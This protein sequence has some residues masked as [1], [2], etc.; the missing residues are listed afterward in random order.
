MPIKV[1]NVTKANKTHFEI[2]MI[3]QTTASNHHLSRPQRPNYT[4]T[5][6]HPVYFRPVRN[7][8]ILSSKNKNSPSHRKSFPLVF[9]T[10]SGQCPLF[11]EQN[12]E[13]FNKV[14][15]SVA[16]DLEDALVLSGT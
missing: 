14:M 2:S 5:I 12:E 13:P 3:I 7:A 10:C 16:S 6:F 9:H 4:D 11:L 15:T 1:I 8:F